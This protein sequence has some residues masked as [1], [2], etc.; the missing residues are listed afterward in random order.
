M[1]SLTEE[2]RLGS[3]SETTAVALAERTGNA[4]VPVA[5]VNTTTYNKTYAYASKKV[6]STI[7]I[8]FP[9]V[10]AGKAISL[11]SEAE[12][13]EL[14]ATFATN[15]SPATATIVAFSVLS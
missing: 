6:N 4:F 2:E 7:K 8:S 9:V 1:D 12:T 11:T 10:D 5:G 14:T 3:H 15:T 13:R